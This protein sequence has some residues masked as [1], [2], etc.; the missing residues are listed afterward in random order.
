VGTVLNPNQA[1]FATTLSQ[2][3]G[4]DPHVIGA[5][6]LAEESGGA[7]SKRAA[8][9]N[10]NW[11][12]IGY[13]DSGAGSITKD[14]TFSDP[15]SAAKATAQFLKGQKWGASPGIKGI[16]S[17]VGK[18]PASQ[19]K[20]IA[21]SGWASSGYDNGKNLFGTYKLVSGQELPLPGGGKTVADVPTPPSK[22]AQTAPPQP[23]QVTPFG[24]TP[25]TLFA[26]AKSHLGDTKAGQGISFIEQALNQSK[27]PTQQGAPLPGGG[28]S[29]IPLYKLQTGKDVGDTALSPSGKGIV[30]AALKFKGTPYSWG[31]G[32]TSGPSKGIA[33]GS[34]TVGFDCSGLLQYSV[35]Q[36]TGRKIPRVAAAQY[37]AANHVDL[38]NAKPGDAVFFGSKS[39]I[40]HVGIYLGDGKFI[41]APHTGD[42]VKISSLAGRSD[43]VGVGRF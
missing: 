15:V 26:A 1:K 43:L 18:D 4:L 42:V 34:K 9:G 23:G 16:L 38:K 31:G 24:L 5:W 37:G 28:F 20:A 22:V 10:N 12:N 14:K 6:T 7:A 2:L 33:Q 27:A 3:T 29:S 21:G 35:F 40:H 11:L 39:N 8:Q 36:A 19:M 41:E 25:A 30:Q 13:F 32:G 17:T